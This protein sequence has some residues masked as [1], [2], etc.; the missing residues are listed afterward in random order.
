MDATTTTPTSDNSLSQRALTWPN[1]SSSHPNSTLQLVPTSFSL[2][3][4]Y[5]RILSI[6][7]SENGRIFLGGEDGCLYEMTYQLEQSDP[8]VYHR[9]YDDSSSSKVAQQLDQF[10]DHDA[11]VPDVITE[12]ATPPLVHLGKR[13]WS[14]LTTVLDP[15]QPSPQ[16]SR[17]C[18]KV[19]R[20]A[21]TP[22]IVKAIVPDFVVRGTSFVFGGP[23]SAA[24]GKIIQI[25]VDEHRGCVYTLSEMGWIATFDLNAQGNN[26]SH[27]MLTA[28]IDTPRT[29]R[30]YLE[31]VSRGQGFPPSTNASQTIGQITFPGGGPAAQAG[32]GGMDGAR[33]ILKHED[34]NRQ[35][36]STNSG[37][38]NR[39]SG[40]NMLKPTSIHV[41][42]PTES[43]RLTLVAV[44]ECGLRYY[45][46]SLTQHVISHGADA[47]TA[48][49]Y[50]G[51]AVRNPLAPS[52]RITLCH[53]RSPPPTDL[54]QIREQ[55]LSSD[56]SGV[57]GGLT[58]RL[59]RSKAPPLVDSA[60][61]KQGAFVLAT[62]D[63]ERIGN[64]V[65]TRRENVI[66]ATC[67][68]TTAHKLDEPMS[69]TSIDKS[70]E[71]D[72]L[73]G[74]YV[75]VGGISESVSISGKFAGGIVYDIVDI[76]TDAR[77][78]YDLIANSTTPSDNELS[79]GL[80]SPYYPPS[81][82]KPQDVFAPAT[83]GKNHLNGHSNSSVTALASVNNA[84]S[85]LTAYKVFGSVVVNMLL[86][87]PLN[88]GIS[89]EP[90]LSINGESDEHP[91]YR[92][93]NRISAKG[94]SG[95]A[96][97]ES[98]RSNS[99]MITKQHIH[100][101]SARLR[102][103]LLRPSTIPLSHTATHIYK[104]TDDLVALNTG[105]LHFFARKSVITRLA[106]AL[107]RTTNNVADDFIITSFFNGYGYKEGCCMCLALAIGCGTPSGSTNDQLKSRAIAA[108]LARAYIP[109][110]TIRPDHTTGPM[111]SGVIAKDPLV[112]DGYDFKS[113][114][115]CEG[116]I[117][118]FSRLVR[119]IWHK[120]AV[121][122]TEGR[123]IK[124]R[125]S[126]KMVQSPA[127]VETIFDD[128]TLEEIGILTRNLLLLIKSVFARAVKN[129]PGLSF[130]T[131]QYMDVDYQDNS[132]VLTQS[133]Q[134]NINLRNAS[135]GLAVQLSHIEAEH[136]ARQLEEKTIHSL[137]RVLARLVQ[138][139]NLMSLLRRAQDMVEFKEVDWG[140]LHGLT[141]SQLVQCPEAQD[142]LEN[143]LNSLVTTSVSRKSNVSVSSA[144][145]DQ[146]ANLFE[147]KCYLF[148]SP[149]SQYAYLGLRCASEAM[150]LPTH[151]PNRNALAIQAAKHLC[152]AAMHW[153]SEPL[154]TGRMIH[155]KGKESYDQI[156]RRAIDSGSPLAKATE[157]LLELEDVVNLVE[158]CLITAANFT[159]KHFMSY[160]SVNGSF[161][162]KYELKWEHNLYHK[163]RDEFLADGGGKYRSPTTKN[164]SS[165]TVALGTEVTGQAAIESCYALIFHHLS[166]LLSAGRSGLADAMV[167]KCVHASDSSFLN[168]FF[169]YLLDNEHT[170]I[171]LRI[172]SSVLCGWL[173]GKGDPNLLWRYYTVQEQYS[174]AGQ[175]AYQKANDRTR[176][177]LTDRIEWLTRS[178]NSYESA[179]AN[180]TTGNFDDLNLR[181][182]EVG[183]ALKIAE[184]QYRILSA[185]DPVTLQ[186]TSIELYDKLHY[187]LVPVTELY[188]D[189]AVAF[190]LLDECLLIMHTC[191]FED[192]ETIQALWTHVICD[193]IFFVPCATCNEV[194]YR[195]LEG[196]LASIGREATFRLLNGTESK[197]S[198]RMLED[199]EWEKSLVRR[200]ST[201][202]KSLYG[203]G[204]SYVFPVE[205]LL[206]NLERTLYDDVFLIALSSL[207]T[208]SLLPSE[209]KQSLPSVLSPGWSLLVIADAGV[210]FLVTMDAYES[211]VP[212][213]DPVSIGRLDIDKS[214]GRVSALLE[215]LEYW[216]ALASSSSKSIRESKNESLQELSVAVTSGRLMQKIEDIKQKIEMM[217]EASTSLLGRLQAIE[218]SISS[219]MYSNNVA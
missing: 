159:D 95:T 133:I 137:Y 25:V 61:Y 160:S 165:L 69:S 116:L 13:A 215:L 183:E 85:S 111:I 41:I 58:P 198:I 212:R 141:I 147:D 138:L 27:V 92:L 28:I 47:V 162:G 194:L 15:T 149:A 112:P 121:V 53:I 119:P 71:Q 73:K 115:L 185:I 86:S 204:A 63:S 214:I 153:H 168:A 32:V 127:K 171:L 199:G 146:L 64:G 113:S 108:A 70:K 52:N 158:V 99:Q 80:P 65:S 18:A 105:G 30:L 190:R 78:L 176:L 152:Q 14:T 74:V 40:G 6:A 81:K 79:I 213:N 191:K 144:Q 21:H 36:Q 157:V 167:S 44:T 135:A 186:R 122:V 51:R 67:S 76:S 46:S 150:A 203:K 34:M 139:L 33:T 218:Q 177:S 120:P 129:V 59:S 134:Y 8:A 101:R 189:Y 217:P 178:L 31:A 12:E 16:I 197:I 88:Y 66:V 118:L 195:Y 7:G 193:E 202:G 206:F 106:E 142:R 87:R 163:R 43:S 84:P 156:A 182:K 179:M 172:N 72:S 94:F 19:N 210:P 143:L 98:L 117:S 131:A 56:T 207:L 170:D 192:T 155:A 196:F 123:M 140:L 104:G 180:F 201:L 173:I 164:T 130:Q 109:K 89:M 54:N 1:Q 154:V 62:A 35:Q 136:I 22:A 174:E 39:A 187:E 103:W 169:S 161:D 23:S 205:F 2:S 90:P 209:L 20:T 75:N 10:Y 38:N 124:L 110:L 132:N 184:R 50:G 68:D 208:H 24:G 166:S 126:D 114:A 37:N 107:I 181:A 200:I 128:N 151:S 49:R 83:N 77:A 82:I 102:P 60:F 97:E 91:N 219:L 148:F 48:G 42:A 45:L 188:H 4:D 96:S 175:V 17:K 145:A 9:K 125:W 100:S 55:D 57:V 26:N 3:T 216:V 5:I 93:S 29:A 11:V 211:I